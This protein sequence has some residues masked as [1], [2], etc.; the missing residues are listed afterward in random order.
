MKRALLLSVVA[1]VAV[2]AGGDIVPAPVVEESTWEFGGTA[3]V[4]YQTMD[5]ENFVLGN[6]RVTVVGNSNDFFDRRSSAAN[7]GLQLRVANKDVIGGFGFGAE[8]SALSTLNLVDYGVVTASMQSAGLNVLDNDI[9]DALSSAWVSQAYLTYGLGNTLHLKLV[10]KNFL[11]H[12]HH[13]LSLKVGMY[14]KTHLK[15]H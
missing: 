8:V 9:D 11:S 5:H 4:Y 6:P 1:S 14:L 12:F 3:K 10:V 15:Q 7:A 13:L 2:M